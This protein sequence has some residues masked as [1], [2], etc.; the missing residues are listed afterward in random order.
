MRRGAELSLTG[1]FD[2]EGQSIP[3]TLTATLAGDTLAGQVELEL[4]WEDEPVEHSLTGTRAPGAA[5]QEGGL[6]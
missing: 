4:P 6:R 5:A 2:D 1:S 3:F